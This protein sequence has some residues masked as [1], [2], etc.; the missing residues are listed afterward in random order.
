[1][2]AESNLTLQSDLMLRIVSFQYRSYRAQVKK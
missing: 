2:L 1:M